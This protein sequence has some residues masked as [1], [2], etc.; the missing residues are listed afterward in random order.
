MTAQEPHW[1]IFALASGIYLKSRRIAEKAL[2]PLNITWPQ[3]GALLNLAQ[4]DNITQKELATRL[5]L[6]TTTTMV[7]CDSLEKKEW[8]ERVKDPKDRRAN[9]IKLTPNGK[10]VF[11][12]AYPI[13]MAKY[14]IITDE[15]DSAKIQQFL[16]VMEELYN[17]IKQH[18]TEEMTK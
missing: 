11:S 3:F 1:K 14:E 6:D 8:L 4:E 16:P 5:E 17:V 9:R 12:I 10:S 7:L 15:V 18:Y 2:K 13:M